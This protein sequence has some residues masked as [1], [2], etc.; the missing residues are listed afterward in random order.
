MLKEIDYV[1]WQ[2]GKFFVSQCINVNVSSFG[3]TIEES[4]EN[5]KEAVELYFENETIDFPKIDKIFLGRES[6]NA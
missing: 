2:E 4:I 6:V 3:E 1:I 5:L